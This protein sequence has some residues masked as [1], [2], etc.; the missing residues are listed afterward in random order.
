MTTKQAIIE[1]ALEEIG[2]GIYVFDASPSQLEAAH[3]RLNNLATQWDGIGITK[4]YNIGATLDEDLPIPDTVINC[5]ALHLAL[6]LA[7]TYGKTIGSETRANARLA[8][9]AMLTTANKIPQV[10]Y[11]DTMP[12]GVGNNQYPGIIRPYYQPD[13]G[14]T[15]NGEQITF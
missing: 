15:S 9:N 8:Y 5:F 6:S 4:S 3:R 2:L 10:Q 11:P 14:L 13:T 1:Q 12:I 7:P